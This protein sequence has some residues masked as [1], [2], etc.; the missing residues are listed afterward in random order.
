MSFLILKV[1]TP[2][3][4]LSQKGNEVFGTLKHG[5]FLSGNNAR[6]SGTKTYWRVP[7]NFLF[8]SVIFCAIFS[9]FPQ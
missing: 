6:I 7:S 5:Y 1:M 4:V 2:Q 3:L 8:Q 9:L